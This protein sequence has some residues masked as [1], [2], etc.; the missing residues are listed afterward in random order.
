[1]CDLTMPLCKK[2]FRKIYNLPRLEWKDWSGKTWSGMACTSIPN[3]RTQFL[4]IY[5]PEDFQT[6]HIPVYLTT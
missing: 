2:C 1:M 4:E 3:G 6:N 5:L